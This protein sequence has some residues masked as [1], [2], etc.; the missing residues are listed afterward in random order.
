MKRAL[1]SGASSGI[2]EAFTLALVQEGYDCV[3]FA[4]RESNLQDLKQR[5]EKIRENSC[6]YLVLDAREENTM[7]IL[8]NVIQDKQWTFDLVINNAGFGYIGDFKDMKES[9]IHDMIEVN[10][11][12]LTRLTYRMIPY[13][14]QGG[15]F[16]Q[17]SSLA[18]SMSG[19]Y[20]N[21]YYATKNYVS[22]FSL[23]CDIEFKSLGL[24]SLAFIPGPVHTEFGQVAKAG[25]LPIFK[26]IKSQDVTQ[27]VKFALK[28]IQKRQRFIVSQPIHRV[29]LWCVKWLPQSWVAHIVANLQ[30][31]RTQ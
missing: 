26:T 3:V 28:G 14:N 16:L 30:K 17:V 19:P 12:F 18:G 15:I 5:C 24:R 2:G 10:V 8:E 9:T 29:L 4:R 21:V 6:S 13:M 22:A 7:D 27:A 25:S 20:M 11:N 31:K 1:I 23:A